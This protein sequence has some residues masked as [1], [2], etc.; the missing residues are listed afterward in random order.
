M[1][2]ETP[3][4]D[5]IDRRILVLLQSDASLPCSK[6]A[7]EVGLSQPQCWRRIQQFRRDGWISSVVAL[8]DRAKLG[9][10]TQ[11]FVHVR[12]NKKDPTSIAEFSRAIRE[13]PEVLECHAI[14]GAF[15]FMLRV[16]VPD[17]DAYHRFHFDKLDQVPHIREV[18]CMTS[19]AQ[20][21]YTTSLPLM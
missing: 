13:L 9:V 19:V 21:K 2:N 18:R 6:I 4:I 20:V 3:V 14:L 8:L 11:L 12:V 16:V 7:S 5:D 15:D 17:I 1:E 10:G